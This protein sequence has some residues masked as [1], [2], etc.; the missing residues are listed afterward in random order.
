MM[1]WVTLFGLGEADQIIGNATADAGNGHRLATEC[2]G[3]PQGIGQAVSLLICQLQAAPRL[4]GDSRPGGVEPVRQP[5]GVAHQSRRTRIFAEA[6]QDA[7]AGGP[8]TGDRIGLHM[9]KQL[10]IDALG[11]APQ[12]Q[13]A[14]CGEVA[15]REIM[16]E[17]VARPA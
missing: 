9:R 12:R 4:D 16:I 6:D 5:L 10:L 1:I 2:F 8:G 7:F 13:F 17:R 11:G 3:K 15:R 14:Q